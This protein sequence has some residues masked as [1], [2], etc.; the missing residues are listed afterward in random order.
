MT[1]QLKHTHTQMLQH[2]GS[3]PLSIHP[4]T[5]VLWVNNETFLSYKEWAPAWVIL[6]LRSTFC[7]I[8]EDPRKANVL[9]RG[10]IF[11]IISPMSW[12]LSLIPIR[13]IIVTVT[14]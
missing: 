14:N 9:M 13:L 4:N 1:E 12:G 2:W 3:Q 6:F 11:S 7:L 5:V 10:H 8:S